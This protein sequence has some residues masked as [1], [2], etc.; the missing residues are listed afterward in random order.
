M[1]ENRSDAGKIAEA[2]QY[3]TQA[4][5]ILDRQSTLI[6]PDNVLQELAELR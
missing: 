1:I 2:R 3:L 5:E 4:L 6:E